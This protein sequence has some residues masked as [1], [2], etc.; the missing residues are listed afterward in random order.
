MLSRSRIA[1][2]NEFQIDGAAT[3]KARRARSVLV[4]GTTIIGASDDRRDGAG[5][6][7]YNRSLR[8]TGVAVRRTLEVVS[9]TLYV[10]RCLI[11]S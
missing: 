6:W 1:E 2:G 11:G 5:A 4:R 10:T 8:Y 3:L 7:V 9:A